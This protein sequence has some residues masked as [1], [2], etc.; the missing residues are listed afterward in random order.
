[1]KNQPR[2]RHFVQ[3]TCVTELSVWSFDAESVTHFSGILVMSF[4]SAHTP[5]WENLFIKYYTSANNKNRWSL[6]KCWSR[7]SPRK[8]KSWLFEVPWTF[9][10]TPNFRLSDHAAKTLLFTMLLR[11]FQEL[12][13][14]FQRKLIF[15]EAVGFLLSPRLVLWYVQPKLKI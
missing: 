12:T 10:R 6:A 15:V 1:M 5:V 3:Q 8:T 7:Y 14:V 13:F 4:T 2:T 11:M 9:S